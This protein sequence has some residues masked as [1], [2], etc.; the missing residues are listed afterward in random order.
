[1]GFIFEVGKGVQVL[2]AALDVQT[3]KETIYLLKYA[4]QDEIMFIIKLVQDISP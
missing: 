2:P 3:L 1:M 4:K